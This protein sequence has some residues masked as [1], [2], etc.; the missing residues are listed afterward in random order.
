MSAV[1]NS[2]PPDG[3]GITLVVVVA[4][5]FMAT[6]DAS[7]V[8][9]ALPVM[10]Q[11]LSE[12]LSAIEWVIASYVM[13]ICST[14][15]MFGRL[16]D[17]VGKSRVFSCGT[18]LF[19]VGSLLCGFC[20]SLVPLIV[21]RFIQGLGASAYMANNQGI[22][23][24]LYP[25]EGRGKALGVLAAS[26]ALG[27]MVGAPLGG[28]I[29]SVL[30]WNYIFYIAV[31]VGVVFY[32]LGLK[33]LPEDKMSV[34]RHFDVPGAVM[35][36]VGTMLL[37]GALIRA[38]Q[39]GFSDPY[40]MGAILA[41]LVLTVMFVWYEARH[42]QPLLDVG[43]FRDGLFSLSLVCAFVSFVCIA[44]YTLL[45]PFYF[46][47]TLGMLPSTAGLLMMTAPFIVAML[48][49]FCGML[50]DRIG[51]ELMTMIGLAIMSVSFLLMSWLDVQSPIWFSVLFLAVMAVGQAL[52]QPANNSIIMSSCP[53]N[54]LGIGGSINALVRNLG[55]YVGVV[56]STTLLYCFMSGK[57]GYAVSDYIYGRDE[58]FV[59]GMKRVYLIL[60]AV[61]LA[62]TLLTVYRLVRA[63][64]RAAV[65][66]SRETAGADLH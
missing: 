26:V 9:I 48:A 12:P 41:S 63:G 52:F 32:V 34:K 46:Q 44:S 37:F 49:A 15:L 6:L 7:I 24:Q 35:Q 8:N 16:G 2:A 27:T 38:Q 53:K 56:L 30:S 47:N 40:I 1:E 65:A 31:P 59:Y 19:T 4:M 60:M 14:L 17:I 57:I 66:I 11:S 39:T 10:S 62:G 55:Q 61:C 21:C 54:K 36:F 42:E 50:A 45:F 28:F 20:S 3:R 33:Y 58:V 13:I 43:M 23:T 25:R 64:R 51:S 22:V 18:L 29:V 5:S